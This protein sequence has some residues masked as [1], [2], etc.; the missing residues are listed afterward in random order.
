MERYWHLP[1]VGFQ[2]VFISISSTHLRKNSKKPSY[3]R[4][5]KY[6]IVSY[7]LSVSH[8]NYQF[9][10]CRILVWPTPIL[11]DLDMI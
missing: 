4:S 11:K 7:H 9:I 6:S 10:L 3:S 2:R 8:P 5:G 1:V